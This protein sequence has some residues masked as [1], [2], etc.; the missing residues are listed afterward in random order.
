MLREQA[1]DL[2]V[3]RPDDLLGRSSSCSWTAR[4]SPDSL[5]H[6][7]SESGPRALGNR[8][9]I[10]D[11][12][13]PGMQDFIN[14]RVKGGEWFRPLA[15]IVLADAA[16]RIFAIDRPAPFTTTRRGS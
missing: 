14:A 16:P 8:S 3:D 6:G 11:A 12:R 5:H 13:H 15:P 1:S 2:V 4:A 10:A 9:I 7:R